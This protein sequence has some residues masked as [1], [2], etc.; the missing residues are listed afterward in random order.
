MNDTRP[1]AP[2]YTTSAPSIAGTNQN[3]VTIA[4]TTAAAPSDVFPGTTLN[5]FCQIQIANKATGWAHVN[6]GVF[7]N[8]VEAT[9]DNGYPV[10]P[11]GVAVVTVNAEVNGASVILDSGTG[12]VVLT[13]GAGT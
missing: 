1:F 11:G 6:F 3:N 8:V 4:A 10:A 9:V 12:D 13:R 2:L 5:D 7:G